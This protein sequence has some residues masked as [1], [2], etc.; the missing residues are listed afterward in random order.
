MDFDWH[1]GSTIGGSA[2][3]GKTAAARSMEEWWLPVS[4]LGFGSGSTSSVAVVEGDDG[5]WWQVADGSAATSLACS[6]DGFA[7]KWLSTVVLF[8][9]KV[10]SDTKTDVGQPY[11]F[12][13]TIK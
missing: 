1:Y 7:Y 3:V 9:L 11:Y 10:Y 5:F 8:G 4:G 2:K 6:F 12:N 13:R